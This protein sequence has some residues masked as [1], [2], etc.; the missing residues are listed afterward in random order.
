MKISLMN[1]LFRFIKSVLCLGSLKIMVLLS[2]ILVLT[3]GE[4]RAEE[5][6]PED[7]SEEHLADETWEQKFIRS[8]I[9]ISDWFDGVAEGL[10]L[11]L[12]GKKV[13]KRRNE[14]SVKLGAST[15]YMEGQGLKTS[16]GIGVNLRLPNIEDY[17]Q[18]K[19]TS[20]DESQERGVNQKFL[21]TAPRENNFGASVGLFRKL[22]N[23]RTSFQPRISL[24]D[25]LKVSHS[26]TF[27]S[28]ADLKTY[29][30][31]PK[32]EFF[33]EPEKGTGIFQAI[34]VNFRLTKVYSLTLINEGEYDD[35]PH[36]FTATNG[37]SLGQMVTARSGLSYNLLFGSNNRSN[38]HLETY[39]LSV[40]W[41]HVI[42]K[43]ILDYQ[44][45]PHL[46]FLKDNSFKG[47]SGITLN[48]NLNF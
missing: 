12:V 37:V 10:D 29:E 33:A 18:L 3:C 26:L 2:L 19:F 6:P 32:I 45:I 5:T 38:Y 47:V 46:D 22:G 1:K 24:Q 11:F 15:Y 17:F 40:A 48:F 4:L 36:I 7:Q 28:V 8:D 34:N 39:S 16:T 44:V 27:E 13:T 30:V 42:Y 43:K 14:S 9:Y 25:P 20:Y 41:S 31:N 21:R 35:K 23:I